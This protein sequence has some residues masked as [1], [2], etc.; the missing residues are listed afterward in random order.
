MAT[1]SQS[2]TGRYDEQLAELRELVGAVETP[3]PSGMLRRVALVALET[4]EAGPDDT[5]HVSANRGVDSV[6]GV[7]LTVTVTH[8]KAPAVPKPGTKAP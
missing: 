2:F 8:T 1:N 7:T 3:S 5:V 4:L 6:G